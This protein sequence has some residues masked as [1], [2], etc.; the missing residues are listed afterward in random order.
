MKAK[1]R[2]LRKIQLKP[3]SLGTMAMREQPSQHFSMIVRSCAIN[4]PVREVVLAR[5]LHEVGFP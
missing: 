4:L 3:R 5:A 2:L 1:T